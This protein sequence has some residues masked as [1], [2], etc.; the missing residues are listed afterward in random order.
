MRNCSRDRNSARRGFD[1]GSVLLRSIIETAEAIIRST[2]ILVEASVETGVEESK[3]R[4]VRIAVIR[5]S[6]RSVWCWGG[7]VWR[8]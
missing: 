3:D 1:T 5:R 2:S 7:E 4:G 6:R 8:W